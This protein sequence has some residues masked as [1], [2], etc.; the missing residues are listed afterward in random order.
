MPVKGFLPNLL[1]GVS[2]QPAAMRL[3]TQLEEQINGFSTPER[4]L[5]KRPP[6]FNVKSLGTGIPADSF[7]HHILR[8]S[9]ERYHV[10][11]KNG[12]L[13]VYDLAGNQKTVS[14]PSG[15]SYLNSVGAPR[16]SFACATN[17]D[18]T[19]IANK[20]VEAA[21]D[22]T[23]GA[24]GPVSEALV[25]CR[26]ANYSREYKLYINDVVVADFQFTSAV[27]SDN[28]TVRRCQAVVAPQNSAKIFFWGAT[29]TGTVN[30]WTGA[31]GV[32]DATFFDGTV[33]TTLVQNLS[34]TDWDIKRYNNVLWIKK[35]N[36][37]SFSIRA[38]TDRDSARDSIVT[39]KDSLQDFS[40]LPN[41]GP[42]GYVVQVSGT[43]VDTFDDYW[44]KI[45]KP[46]DDETN[47][48]IVWKECP[49]PGTLTEFDKATMPHTLVRNGD[50]TFTF[51]QSGWVHRKVGD[52]A[53]DTGANPSFVGHTI[54]D[55]FFHRG[56][57]G[58]LGNESVVMTR[59]SKF[60]DFWRTTMTTI[61]DDDPI[62]VSGADDVV[63]IFKHAV[64]FNEELY[65]SFDQG[66]EKLS[67][68]DIL[69][70][71]T[72]KLTLAVKEAVDVKV[73]PA[74]TQDTIVYTASTDSS[75]DVLSYADVREVY[76]AIDTTSERK[77]AQS[78]S[79]HVAGYIPKNIVKLVASAANNIVIGLTDSSDG[80]LYIYQYHWSGQTKVQSA[81][82]RWE[83]GSG[84]QVISAYFFDNVLHM[85][86]LRG[87]EAWLEKIPCAHYIAD[88]GQQWMIRLDRRTAPVGGGTFTDDGDQ[89]TTLFTLPYQPD[90]STEA[91]RLDQFGVPVAVVSHTGFTITVR[92][93]MVG[94]QMVFG[95]SYEKRVTLSELF[96]RDIDPLHRYD[97][98]GQAP[99]IT[100]QSD[101]LQILRIFPHYVN[102]AYWRAE[103]TP[104]RGAAMRV[105]EFSAFIMQNPDTDTDTIAVQGGVMGVRVG[106][107]STRILVDLVNDTHYPSAFT[108]AEWEGHHT[109]RAG[110]AA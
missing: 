77:I 97:V 28:G 105:K 110:I 25:F 13:L 100:Q 65:L 75:G 109:Q 84:V 94:V 3:P 37:S 20:E 63:A 36:G 43:P 46:D 50:G 64:T 7:V 31:D 16:D 30:G 17:A 79:D 40:D 88:F 48:S 52:S 55:V 29:T 32:A 21:M 68:G 6:T 10:I 93:N 74:T 35:K 107:K 23:S 12:D 96:I 38:E 67:A 11:I 106:G 58:F 60:F 51:D 76:V 33:T 83:L 72:V 44:V 2:R 26:A 92:G 8:D 47:D 18:Y 61:V 73:P 91:V 99:I 42:E 102:S 45:I 66:L 19:F 39:I 9:V 78:V 27:S 90:A 5:Q 22:G 49:K 103:V 108:S 87:S 15:K 85:V 70:Q 41:H 54:N 101:R 89:G 82:H 69:T 24:P 86:L 71:K 104:S 53:T 98:T 57:L 59:P 14:F 62:D 4:G 95:Q 34:P 81:W 1:S 80:K 56:R